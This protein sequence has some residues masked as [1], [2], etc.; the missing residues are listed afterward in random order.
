LAGRGGDWPDPAAAGA[1]E[2][3]GLDQGFDPE[4]FSPTV[5]NFQLASYKA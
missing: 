4:V 3:A 5:R 2:T 1:S